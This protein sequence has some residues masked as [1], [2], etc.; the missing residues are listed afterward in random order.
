MSKQKRIKRHNERVYITKTR[1]LINT[2]NH[3][4]DHLNLLKLELQIFIL[5]LEIATDVVANGT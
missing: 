4:R 5:A 2:A 1:L 3:F